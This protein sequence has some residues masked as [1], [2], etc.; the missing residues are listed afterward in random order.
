MGRIG[1][2]CCRCIDEREQECK[3]RQRG[4]SGTGIAMTDPIALKPRMQNFPRSRETP[5]RQKRA[6][7]SSAQHAVRIFEKVINELFIE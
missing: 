4:Y 5:P 6:T 3:Q 2:P 1:T 7:A